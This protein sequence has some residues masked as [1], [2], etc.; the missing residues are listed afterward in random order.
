MIKI[1]ECIVCGDILDSNGLR[2]LTH[3]CD[4]ERNQH[5]YQAYSTD[6]IKISLYGKDTMIIWISNEEIE[7]ELNHNANPITIAYF[8]ISGLGEKKLYEKLKKLFN[9]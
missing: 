8:D 3:E 1:N 2:S 4:N 5:V 7:I 9:T 6:G